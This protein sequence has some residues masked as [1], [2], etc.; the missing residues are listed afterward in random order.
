MTQVS[1]QDIAALCIGAGALMSGIASL[2]TA[3]RTRRQLTNIVVPK[4][5]Q[6]AEHTE[7]VTTIDQDVKN[8]TC[9]PV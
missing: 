7:G 5:E 1:A 8:G 6:L 2:I 9:P 3:R 4:I